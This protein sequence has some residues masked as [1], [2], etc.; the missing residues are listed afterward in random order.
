MNGRY[1]NFFE[2]LITLIL[3]ITLTLTFI[4]VSFFCT[5]LISGIFLHIPHNFLQHSNLSIISDYYRLLLYLVIPWHY[6]LKLRYIPVSKVGIIHFADVK[7]LMQVGLL[8]SISVLLI[9]IMGCYYQKKR[10]QQWTLV[11]LLKEI[12]IGMVI[13]FVLAVI[14]FQDLFLWFH[15]TFFTNMDW[16]F[17]ISQDPII[18]ILNNQFD[19]SFFLVWWFGYFLLVLVFCKVISH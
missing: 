9:S 1:Y 4:G 2:S 12:N 3:G 5:L 13:F 15:Y 6:S 18:V 16:I 14:N 7:G 8:I 19:I 17:K 10:Y 11:P